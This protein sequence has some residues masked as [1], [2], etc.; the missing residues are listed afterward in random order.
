M[1]EIRKEGA[2]WFCWLPPDYRLDDGGDCWDKRA[3]KHGG[4]AYLFDR[5]QVPQHTHS[6]TVTLPHYQT[7]KCQ[8]ATRPCGYTTVKSYVAAQLR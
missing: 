6:H 3:I 5:D 4:F 1:P 7:A 2:Y 8:T